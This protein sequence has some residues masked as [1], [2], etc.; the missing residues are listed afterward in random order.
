MPTMKPTILALAFMI[1]SAGPVPAEGFQGNTHAHTINSDGDSTP[2]AVVRW[3]REHGYD[4]LFI[5]DHGMITNVEPLNALFG[6][7]GEFLV[8]SGEEV[9]SNSKSPELYVHVNALGPKSKIAAQKGTN[10]RDTLQM[11]LDAIAAGGGLAQINHPNFF[12]Q[13][14]ADDIAS[15]KGARLLEIMNM[16]PIVNSLGAG[17][18]AP[19]AEEIWDQVLSR[20][21]VIW[22]VASDD[23]HQ[24]KESGSST[25]GTAGQGAVPGRGWIVVR[26]EHL[27]VEEIMAAIEKGDFYASTGVALKDYQANSK[28]ITIQVQSREAYQEKYRVEFI[29]NHGKTLQDTTAESSVYQIKGNEGY[30]RGRIT[31]SNGQAA[32]TQPVFTDGRRLP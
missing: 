25:A 4:F 20:G 30:I 21:M 22:G 11:D 3:Y 6:S 27:K 29:G 2:D 32:W 17:P 16:H 15:V 18:V 12:W 24:L 13:L 5:T 14:T 8:L 10:A 19:S 7:D 9:T 23:M 31:N 28:Q 26:A 1:V